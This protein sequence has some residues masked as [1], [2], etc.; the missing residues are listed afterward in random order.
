MFGLFA[1]D[2]EGTVTREQAY[3]CITSVH[4]LPEQSWDD[5][6]T[7][8]GDADEYDQAELAGWLGY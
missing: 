7:E 5:F 3:R 6:L 8:H 2:L 4:N 1:Q